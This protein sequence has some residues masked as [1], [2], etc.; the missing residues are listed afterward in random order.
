MSPNDSVLLVTTDSNC[1]Q[2]DLVSSQT[3]IRYDP[4]YNAFW[5]LRSI[6]FPTVQTLGM[7][8]AAT[9]L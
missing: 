7:I 2:R 6:I 9:I 3:F 1:I 4:Q 5:G 8:L